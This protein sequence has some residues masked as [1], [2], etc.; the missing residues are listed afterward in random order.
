MVSATRQNS[1]PGTR[2]RPAAATL[3]NLRNRLASG[4]LNLAIMGQFKRGKSTLLNALVGEE[5][6]PTSVVPLTAVPTFVRFG[7][8]L[9]LRVSYTDGRPAEQR[10]SGA[11]EELRDA[12]TGL[13]TE[14][15][16]PQNHLGVAQV[17][18]LLPSPLLAHGVELIDTPWIGS[19]LRHNTEAT[20]SSSRFIG[21]E[22]GLPSGTDT[23]PGA[24]RSGDRRG[25]ATRPCAA[26][27]PAARANRSSAGASRERLAESGG[28]EEGRELLRRIEAQEAD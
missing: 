6:L 19:T 20:L 11:L 10:R 17:E 28:D 12:L 15:G 23:R 13:V 21:Y 9:S 25:S 1:L 27:F 2:A 5:L 16:N 8:A 22:H 3:S 7:D 4:R 26:R 18:I 14:A 24:W